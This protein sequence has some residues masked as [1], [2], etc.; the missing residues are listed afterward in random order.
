MPSQTALT[1]R[2]SLARH[3][4]RAQRDGGFL[5]AAVRTEIQERLAEVNRAFTTPAVVTA[6]P[7]PWRTLLPHA[8]LLDDR[9]TLPLAEAAHDLVIHALALHWA[10]D[11]V[12]QLIQCRR[13]LRPD[14]LLIAAL[15]GG[16]T[17]QE[18]RA[19]LAE[20]EAQLRGGLSPR[21]APMGEIR[22]LGALLQRAGLALPVADSFTITAEYASLPALAQDLRAM[23]ETNALAARDRRMPPK[24]LFADAEAV[25]RREY[26]TREGRLP[27]TFEVICLTGW[28]A[29]A[30]QPKPLRPGSAA[31]RLADALGTE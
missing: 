22:D 18:L 30:S 23:G 26:G 10:N 7:A 13:A 6:F 29:D 5:Q 24:R 20:A 4:G 25:Y 3:R 15:F 28:A 11:P 1:D 2:E 14:G 12:G 16:R 31:A 27:A 17:L 9:E 21:V 8:K 19:A